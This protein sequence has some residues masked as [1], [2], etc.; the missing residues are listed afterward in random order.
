MMISDRCGLL[1]CLAR[2]SRCRIGQ[3]AVWLFV[4][5]PAMAFA[6]EP[7]VW[8]EAEQFDDAG[9]WVNDPQFVDVM[10][11]PYLLANA[12]GTPVADAVT[13]VTIPQQ[14][15]YHLWVRCRD[16][17]PKHSP[18]K[19]Q[20]LVGGKAS[21]TTFGVAQSDAWQWIDGGSFSL[22]AG[23][24]ELRLHDL[25]GWW[26][27]CDAVVLTAGERPGDQSKVLADQREQNGGVSTKIAAKGPY[28]VVVV[29]GGLA[30]CAA[31]IAAARHDCSVAFIQDRPILG[32]NASAEVR[33]AVS[34]DTS[35]EPWDPRETGIIEEL[36]PPRRRGD[37]SQHY[38]EVV[39][40]QEGIDLFL[41]TRATGAA[42]AN[43]STIQSVDAMDV[44]TGQRYRFAAKYFIDC[45]GDGWVG[46][47]AGAVYRRGREARSEFNEPA[48]PEQADKY[49]LS[50]SLNVSGFATRKEPV[51]F[52]APE[53]CPHWTSCDQFDQSPKLT[54]HSNGDL[55]PEGWHTRKPSTG[56]HPDGRSPGN[57]TWWLECGGT[58]DTIADAE[59]IRDE[60]FCIKLG[61][62]DHVKNHCPQFR[63]VNRNREFIWTSYV[64]GKRESRRLE[65]DY[66]FSQRDYMLQPIH[67]DGVFYAG[68]NVDP[69]HPQGFWTTGPQ[70][71]RLYHYKV[72]VPF[73]ILYSKNID[74]LLMA[75]RNV[76]ATHI[77]FNGVRVQ[78]TTCVMGQVVGTAAGLANRYT[79]SPRGICYERIGELQQALLR[80]GCYLM[81][82]PNEDPQDLALETKVTASSFGT[83][84]DGRVPHG[85]TIHDMNAARA[86]MFAAKTPQL[87]A[88]EL[89]LRSKRTE[90]ITVP[91]TL[92]AANKLG[93]F[94][95]GRVLAE[96]Q[97]EVPAGSAGWVRFDLSEKVQPGHYYYVSLP[98]TEGLQW[99]LYP[100]KIEDTAR[101]YGGPD[102][103]SMTH[104]YRYRL[105][106]GGEPIAEEDLPKSHQ[107]A[108][109]NVV[110]GWNR[111]VHGEPNSWSPDFKQ[112]GPHW[113]ELDFDHPVTVNEV[114][115]T[116]QLP[117]M[118][119][120]AYS[121]TAVDGE[122]SQTVCEIE[123]NTLRRRVHRFDEVKASR[124]RLTLASKLDPAKPVRICEIRV[125]GK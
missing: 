41:N 102:W 45:T 42:K 93:D 103:H 52:V 72:C 86:T 21:Q 120:K 13:S 95:S 108:P 58:Q 60:L 83:L 6:A 46:F 92:C 74:N 77:A 104:S 118:A 114:H 33:V 17:L 101:A 4:L 115:V 23:D 90:P 80:D 98:A 100:L 9:G 109:T 122:K 29:G 3:M 68:Y 59:R 54:V 89:Y 123:D 91:L 14:G 61:L 8:I 2:R 96:T 43:D 63:E 71:F 32:G 84:D 112:P 124:L 35:H 27:R 111:A 110:N 94:A 73:R 65:G 66:I 88:I 38:E 34:G 24:V 119:A 20:V 67:S 47:W 11:S 113:I 75:G 78:R 107:L 5:I 55:P 12:I 97:A 70:A 82:V 30:G 37:K 81:E 25:T 36:E 48:A 28:D 26:G 62:W 64:A 76:S 56:R 7:V 121:L 125:Y 87:D 16:W 99:D 105:V 19:F 40:A 22:P 49:S 10:G 116:F 51:E 31:A 1:N 39:R 50:T 15:D 53:W 18:G 79:T 44:R 117:E 69:H 57:G 106:P 85:G